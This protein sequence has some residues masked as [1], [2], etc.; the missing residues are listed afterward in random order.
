MPD[1]S[2][3][4]TP[5]LD[6]KAAAGK[7]V[8]ALFNDPEVKQA[9]GKLQ[10]RWFDEWRKAADPIAREALHAK[11]RALEDVEAEIRKVVSDGQLAE[12]QVRRRA[13]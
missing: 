7:R 8:E 6:Q 3:L 12:N 9:L 2:E 10:Q 11:A 5:D 13:K 1:L 4:P